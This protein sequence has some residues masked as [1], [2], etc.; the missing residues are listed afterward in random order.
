MAAI[1]ISDDEVGAV[2]ELHESHV[3]PVGGPADEAPHV[4]D[5]LPRS[6]AEKRNP[7]QIKTLSITPHKIDEASVGGDRGPEKDCTLHGRDDLHVAGRRDLANPQTGFV[8]IA[9]NVSDVSS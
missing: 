7:P 8:P 9:L 1:G 2:V 3:L 6:P 4:V 5:E